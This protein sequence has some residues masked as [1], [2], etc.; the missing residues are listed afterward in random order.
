MTDKLALC[1]FCPAHNLFCRPNSVLPLIKGGLRP[2]SGP[3][4]LC[5]EETIKNH[6]MWFLAFIFICYERV[7]ELVRDGLIGFI[8]STF[9]MATLFASLLLIN[10]QAMLANSAGPASP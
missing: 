3:D 4:S 5:D 6:I 1:I 2:L 8:E 9:G 10:G 7:F